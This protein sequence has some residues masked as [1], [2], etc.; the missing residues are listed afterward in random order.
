AESV[1]CGRQ[2]CC[3]RCQN[4]FVLPL[5]EQGRQVIERHKSAVD[6]NGPPAAPQ[7]QRHRRNEEKKVAEPAPPLT[8]FVHDNCQ[9]RNSTTAIK[10]TRATIAANK[11]FSSGCGAT[12]SCGVMAG[13]A[14]RKPRLVS[15]E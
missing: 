14:K 12:G 15:C 2:L 4:R 1:L 5:V 6:L 7:Q 10:E 11:P 13:L 9:W 8:L 3:N